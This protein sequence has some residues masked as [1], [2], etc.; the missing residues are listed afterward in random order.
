[1][2]TKEQ[3]QKRIQ[4][5]IE[6]ALIQ[7]SDLT[8][9]QNHYEVHVNC[10]TLKDLSRIEQHKKIMGIFSEELKS[11]EIHALSIKVQAS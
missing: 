10:S 6:G 3:I 11:G 9:E 7:V 1:M 2:V 8:G 5:Q 4:S